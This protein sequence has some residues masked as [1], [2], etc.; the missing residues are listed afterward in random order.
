MASTAD[1]EPHRAEL[2]LLRQVREEAIEKM[3]A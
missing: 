2:D 3:L 1:I